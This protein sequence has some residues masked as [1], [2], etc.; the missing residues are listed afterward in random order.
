VC[1]SRKIAYKTC[2]TYNFTKHFEK[3]YFTSFIMLR[4]YCW[5]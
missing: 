2:K 1:N 3:H 5:Y 4:T